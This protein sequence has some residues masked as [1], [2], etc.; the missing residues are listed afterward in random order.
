MLFENYFLLDENRDWWKHYEFQILNCFSKAFPTKKRQTKRS[1]NREGTSGNIINS[2]ISDRHMCLLPR[3]KRKFIS[4]KKK[5][6]PPITFPTRFLI[7]ETMNSRRENSK[8]RIVV[9]RYRL[10]LLC[11]EP[12]FQRNIGAKRGKVAPPTF[13][14]FGNVDDQRSRE[15]KGRGKKKRTCD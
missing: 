12:F 6:D 10:S 9:C 7:V 4:E 8:L 13:D 2:Y 3:R 5:R 1:K 11:I 14:A 15:E